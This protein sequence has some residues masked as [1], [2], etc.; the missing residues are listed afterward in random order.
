MSVIGVMPVIFNVATTIL[1]SKSFKT[2]GSCDV[3]VLCISITIYISIKINNNH[4]K[5]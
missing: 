3:L 2:M 1:S 5:Y 4:K